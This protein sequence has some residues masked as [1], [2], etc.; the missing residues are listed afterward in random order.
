LR[1]TLI[2]SW[3]SP[4]GISVYAGDVYSELV[5][6]GHEV[7]VLAYEE[8]L[9]TEVKLDVPVHRVWR[10][11]QP[12]GW[13]VL[14][15]IHEFQPDLI[16][17]Q[18]EIGFFCPGAVWREWLECLQ[19]TGIPVVVTYHS[20]PDVPT[21]LTDLPV[22]VAIVCSPL[23]AALLGA[24]A[25]FPVM[26]IEHGIDGTIPQEREPEPYSMASFGF[27]AAGKGYHRLLEAMR[28]LRPELPELNLTILGS[29]TPRAYAQQIQY[30]QKLHT[31]VH[32]LGLSGQVDLSCGF[33]T[34]HEVQACL[35]RKAVGLLHYDRTDRMRVHADFLDDPSDPRVRALGTS[36]AVLH[37]TESPRVA[38]LE[39]AGSPGSWAELGTSGASPATL[40]RP[41][42]SHSRAAHLDIVPGL[43]A[44]GT[45]GST[46][47]ASQFSDPSSRG[48]DIHPESARPWLPRMGAVGVRCQSAALFRMWSAGLP[49][50]VSQA[51]HFE[52]GS[53]AADALIRARDVPE[54]AAEIRRLFTDQKAYQAAVA[55]LGTCL[56]RTWKDVADDYERAF[57]RALHP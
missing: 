6:R 12:P 53:R 5:R 38:V 47:T 45:S 4:C 10:I 15:K 33:R 57:S 52:V 34:Q 36:G 21:V 40:A 43:E 55:R 3:G 31:L 24:R 30:F 7:Q 13:Q 1:I 20:L 14:Q 41:E 54:L 8:S 37:Q 51:Q 44:L 2:T 27:L 9:P 23:G 46:M 25:D 48:D 42:P 19:S 32:E 56:T 26:A 29:L 18:H 49:C 28:L 11:N 35:S 16:Q 22:A 39:T 17:V 50:I